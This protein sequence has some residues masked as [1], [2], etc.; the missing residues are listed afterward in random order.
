MID[1]KR[2][3][4]TCFLALFACAPAA[5]PRFRKPGARVAGFRM[6]DKTWPH[7]GSAKGIS[8]GSVFARP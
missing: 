2:V 7:G 6:D 1:V 8:H 4:V 5:A 3:P